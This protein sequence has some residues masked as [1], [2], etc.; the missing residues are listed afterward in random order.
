M[1][2]ARASCPAWETGKNAAYPAG[3][4]ARRAQAYPAGA[5]RFPQTEKDRKADMALMV[6]SAFLMAASRQRKV[7]R[8]RRVF[9]ACNDAT[10]PGARGRDPSGPSARTCAAFS[11]R[12]PC[13]GL[14]PEKEDREG[15]RPAGSHRIPTLRPHPSRRRGGAV[16]ARETPGTG[17]GATPPCPAIFFQISLSGMPQARATPAP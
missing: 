4:P 12:H 13:M 5:G 16:A 17:S 6:M 14:F 11:G 2:Q 8:V 1:Q 10:L 3:P 7:R 15:H 9:R